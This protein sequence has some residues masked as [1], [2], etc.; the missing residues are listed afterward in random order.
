MN[1][2]NQRP[3]H[4]TEHKDTSKQLHMSLFR[5]PAAARAAK[6]LDRSLFSRTIPTAAASLKD[7]RL[8]SKYRT[9]L[10]ATKELLILDRLSPIDFDPDPTLAAQ[11]RKCL[12]LTPSVKP[13][14]MGSPTSDCLESI[15]DSWR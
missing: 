11:G 15:A 4:L 7:N 9:A 10:Q 12:I 5:A 1:N 14:G 6:T 2:L 8:I 13:D 3:A